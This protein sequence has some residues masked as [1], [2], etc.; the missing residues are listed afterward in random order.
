PAFHFT[1]L[2]FG[3][4][5]PWPDGW[6]LVHFALLGALVGCIALGLWYRVAALLFAFGFGY[7]FLLEQARYQNHLYLAGLLALLLACLPAE[8]VWSLD[9][10][11]KPAASLSVVPA[12]A[13]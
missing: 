8:R 1:Y 12:W 7:V 3:W 2:G 4:V 6:M 13:L 5:R 9:A 11:R 10:W